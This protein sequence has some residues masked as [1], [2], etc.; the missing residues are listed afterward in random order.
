M[1]ARK[2]IRQNQFIKGMIDTPAGRVP[3]AGTTLELRDRFG[4]AAVRLG[5][6]RPAYRVTPGLYAAGNPGADSPVFVSANYKL[7]FDHLRAALTE[8]DSWILVLDT[9]GIN[10]WCAA[11]KGSFGTREIVTRVEASGLESVVRHRILILPQLGAPGVAAHE[12][13]SLSGFRILYG[14]VRA[15]DIPAWMAAG[16]RKDADMSRVTFTFRERIVLVPLELIQAL[17][18]AA[19]AGIAGILIEA[20]ELRS[21]GT[22]MLTGALP[23]LSASAA[24]AVL[25]PVLLPFLPGKSFAF[26]GAQVGLAAG[27]CLW[28]VMNWTLIKGVSILLSMTAISVWEGL[29]FTGSSTYTNLQGVKR[30]MR[31]GLVPAI[32]AGVL[33]IVLRVAW[34]LAGKGG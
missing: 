30:D 29:A 14:P 15:K 25:V 1:M 27:L 24:G 34:T 6:R 19:L 26:K 18:L 22:G 12:V 13:Q 16:K 2:P 11:G 10:V 8:I 32:V 3:V 21:F 9:A 20:L 4:A 28:A 31:M 7:S 5:I 23:M 17:P 33:S